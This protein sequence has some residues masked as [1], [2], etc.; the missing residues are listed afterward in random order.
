MTFINYETR[1]VNCKII[2]Y[3]LGASG[4]YSN[5]TW[6]YQ[7]LADNPNSFTFLPDRQLEVLFFDFL[8]PR[9]LNVRG[10]G[11][12]IHLYTISTRNLEN[13]PNLNSSYELI[14]KGVDGL[15]F[16]ADSQSRRIQ[17][18]VKALSELNSGLSR[19]GYDLMEMPYSLQLNKRDLSDILPVNQLQSHLSFKNEPLIEAVAKNGLGVMETFQSVTNQILSELWK[20]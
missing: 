2:Y 17:D 13:L 20:G 7:N 3:G 18:N 9:N 5:L 11:I 6:I 8:L 4:K 10:F 15:V 12:R 19:Q 16:V 14:F 1:E